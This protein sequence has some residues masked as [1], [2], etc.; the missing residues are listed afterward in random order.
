MSHK[1]IL[2]KVMSREMQIDGINSGII[3]D[4]IEY[5][6]YCR[7]G[8]VRY[9]QKNNIRFESMEEGEERKLISGYLSPKTGDWYDDKFIQLSTKEQQTLNNLLLAKIEDVFPKLKYKR[10]HDTP[11]SIA[12]KI[13]DPKR[14]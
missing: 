3:Y 7:K 13:F 12:N 11:H 10:T 4:V 6:W 1:R 5:Q 2:E 8:V 9:T 14:K